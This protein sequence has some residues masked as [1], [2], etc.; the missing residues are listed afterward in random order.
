MRPIFFILGLVFVSE[1]F[2]GLG[3]VTG[4]EW[5]SWSNGHLSVIV[6]RV[7]DIVELDKNRNAGTHQATLEPLLTLLGP[8]NTANTPT[9]QVRFFWGIAS[10]I[11]EIP[12]PGQLILAV[13]TTDVVNGDEKVRSN[14]ILSD[15]CT[16]MPNRS[17]LVVLDGLNDPRLMETIERIRVARAHPD[18]D[19]YKAATQP[20]TKPSN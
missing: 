14:F 15:I 20:A 11:R 7:H 18:P 1:A 10:S 17:S 2:A 6:A 4:R 3:T 9:L 5:E 8:F 19:P 16:F 13:V 12:I